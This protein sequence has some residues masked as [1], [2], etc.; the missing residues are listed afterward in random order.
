MKSKNDFFFFFLQF[1]LPHKFWRCKEL[2]G[3]KIPESSFGTRLP[4]CLISSLR[5]REN[6]MISSQ[7]STWDFA[8]TINI[9]N[10]S[11]L[12]PNEW[13][14]YTKRSIWQ[15]WSLFILLYNFVSRVLYGFW[16][17]VFQKSPEIKLNFSSPP[18]LLE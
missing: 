15:K 8:R 7:Q 10:D 9:H 6:K 16:N 12:P 4:T 13:E 14:I 5:D 1:Y 18:C 17:A 11:Y 3:D 2:T